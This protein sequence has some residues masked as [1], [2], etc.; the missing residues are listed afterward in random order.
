MGNRTVYLFPDNNIVEEDNIDS[1]F[2]FRSYL[3]YSSLRESCFNCP[4]ACMDRVADLSLGDFWGGRNMDKYKNFEGT[5]LVLVNSQKGREIWSQISDLVKYEID[6]IEATRD[7]FA[8]FSPVKIFPLKLSRKIWFIKCLPLYIQKIIFQNGFKIRESKYNMLLK[9]FF[10]PYSRI[11]AKNIAKEA[12]DVRS[13]EL[14]KL[15]SQI[16]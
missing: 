15:K 4:Y 3:T 16:R 10:F 6:F 8:I 13:R 14:A 12:G 7:N 11:K 2:R 9:L 1:D 5:S